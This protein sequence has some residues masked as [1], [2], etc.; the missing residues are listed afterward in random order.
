M[1]Q[2]P[3]SNNN[4]S[5]DNHTNISNVKENTGKTTKKS[6]NLLHIS[7]DFLFPLKRLTGFHIHSDWPHLAK[8]LLCSFDLHAIFKCQW[9]FRL[10]YPFLF[11]LKMRNNYYFQKCPVILEMAG[12]YRPEHTGSVWYWK[13]KYHL[14]INVLS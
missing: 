14:F 3:I 6:W 9:I 11:Q 12:P 1:L 2:N 13:Q 10:Y 5:Y 8:L 4:K 7:K